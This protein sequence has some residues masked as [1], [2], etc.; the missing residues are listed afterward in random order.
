MPDR[1]PHKGGAF[2]GKAKS[3]CLNCMDEQQYDLTVPVNGRAN[4]TISK[5]DVRFGLRLQPVN[6]TLYLYIKKMECI[7]WPIEHE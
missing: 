3:R 6:A 4:I 2:K 7:K 5:C 1:S